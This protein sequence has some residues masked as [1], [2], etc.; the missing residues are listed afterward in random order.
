MIDAF[1]APQGLSLAPASGAPPRAA[2]RLVLDSPGVTRDGA[3]LATTRDL[4]ESLHDAVVRERV[5]GALGGYGDVLVY[6]DRGA[7]FEV[8]SALVAA[9][10]MA[11]LRT[12]HV[13]FA[14]A[15]P[16]GRVASLRL[17]APLPP[18]CEYTF[19]A[20]APMP[21]AGP[22]RRDA[23]VMACT[24]E[25]GLRATVRVSPDGY[26]VRATGANLAPGCD[27]IGTGL[28]VRGRD[29]PALQRCLA[30]IKGLHREFAADTTVI[31]TAAP[32]TRFEDVAAVIS[33][34]TLQADA[35]ILFAEATLG[36]AQ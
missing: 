15:G 35:S 34:A 10:G 36:F 14:V 24:N 4:R 5:V 8:V 9:L 12:D 16:D 26:A 27:D 29:L 2:S 19:R 23:N 11:G 25:P 30:R 17:G 7:M 21:D 22:Q 20:A 31:V 1:A 28:A 13:A 18:E 6:V 32:A 3:L 33:A